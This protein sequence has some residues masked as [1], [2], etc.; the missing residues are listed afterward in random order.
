MKIL[1]PQQ[2][3]A[4][5][6]YTIKQEPIKSI[7]LM[8]R[9]SQRFV[10]RFIH[11]FQKSFVVYIFCG[12]GNN[13]GD[14]F[15]IGRLLSALGYDVKPYL[16]GALDKLSHECSVNKTIFSKR[17]DITHLQDEQQIPKTFSESTVVIDAI[18]GSGLSRPLEGI[19]AT[20]INLV[21]EQHC[22]RVA[23]DVPSGFQTEQPN[24][25]HT[26]FQAD[27]TFTFQA[28]KLGFFFPENYPYVGKWE[29]INIDLDQQY[30]HGLPSTNYFLTHN[31]IPRLLKKRGK[32]DHKGTHGHALLCAGKLTHQHA[33]VGAAILAARAALRSGLGLLTIHSPAKACP[34]L[35]VSMPEAMVSLDTHPEV[36]STVDTVDLARYNAIGIGPG[37]GQD[38]ATI[39]FLKEVISHVNMPLVVDADALNI[40]SENK[41]LL[42][43]LPAKSILT[44]HPK[45]F[46]RLF[47]ATNNSFERLK[48]QKSISQE[49]Q[50]IIVYKGAHTTISFPDGSA[51]FNTTGNSGMATAGTGDVLCGIIMSLLAQGYS[52]EKAACLGVFLHGLAGDIASEKTSSEAMIA[53]DLIKHLA[54]AFTSIKSHH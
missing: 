7:D 35:Q 38:Q 46:Q 1:T 20:L 33:T 42:S 21:N 19:Y 13:G 49:H 44:P 26:V 12:T 14:G 47:G 27:L 51:H 16:I 23:V 53:S 29:S 50:L 39:A 36:L 45:E 25:G 9:A 17:V 48:L 5:D 2:I 54:D 37:I 8:E 22:P 41:E 10:D 52:P 30:I 6:A 32:F 43:Q 11:Y 18:F 4:A 31:Y 28:P 40:I 24:A 15:A 3:R 34:I